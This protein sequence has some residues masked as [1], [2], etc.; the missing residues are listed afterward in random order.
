MKKIFFFLS[1]IVSSFFCYSQPNIVWQKNFGD[2]MNDVANSIILSSDGNYVFAGKKTTFNKKDEAWIAKIDTNGNLINEKSYGG[3]Q[4]DQAYC[5]IELD[6][7]GFAIAGQNQ[8]KSNGF[9]DAW[10]L[11]TNNIFKKPQSKITGGKIWDEVYSVIEINNNLLYAG[12][13]SSFGAGA[14][15]AWILKTT[16]K[17]Q[18]IFDKTYGGSDYDVAKCAIESFDGSIFFI[19]ST[20][21]ESA[22]KK[23]AWLVNLD[24][25][26][27][28]KWQKTYGNSGFDIA[29]DFV[30]TNDGGFLIVGTTN[31]K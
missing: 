6:N 15:D 9:S 5:I 8:S 11:S 17:G 31:S 4:V 19:G 29:N 12:Y 24:A 7:S 10:F 30:Q 2:Y 21:S 18:V 22:G 16:D 14:A 23:D 13:T 20:E 26:G 27:N 3:K 28:L 1:V 25:S